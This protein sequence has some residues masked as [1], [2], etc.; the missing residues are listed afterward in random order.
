MTAAPPL[1]LVQFNPLVG[2]VAGNRARIEARLAQAAAPAVWA[3][4]ELALCGYPPE[5]LLLRG[6]FLDR[7]EAALEEL[8][9]AC[10]EL[11][12][13]P[14]LRL[15]LP[16]IAEDGGKVPVQVHAP[17]ADI[18]RISILVADNPL[19]LISVSRVPPRGEPYV[20][21][22]IRVRESSRV[23]ALAHSRDGRIYRAARDI[24]VTAGGC[25]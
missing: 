9:A 18:E 22:R 16:D 1:R 13:H 24:S 23:I 10:G 2:D 15:E 4:P 17:A 8:A 14:E 25:G 20:S 3:Y 19:P 12:D 6:D 5:D 21:L 11:L 7:A